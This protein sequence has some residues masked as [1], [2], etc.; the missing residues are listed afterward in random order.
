MNT[1]YYDTDR[2][3][4]LDRPFEFIPITRNE[5]REEFYNICGGRICG[6]TR[7]EFRRRLNEKYGYV[8]H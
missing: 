2:L 1:V 3:K 4:E 7:E 5:A 8:N 6:Y